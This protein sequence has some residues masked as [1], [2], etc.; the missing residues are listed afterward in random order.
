MLGWLVG[1]ALH[2]VEQLVGDLA[3]GVDLALDKLEHL[4]LLGALPGGWKAQEVERTLDR[5][6]RVSKLVRE[7]GTLALVVDGVGHGS[8]R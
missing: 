1:L 5:C 6:Q 4:F 8:N 2:D 3:D 7:R